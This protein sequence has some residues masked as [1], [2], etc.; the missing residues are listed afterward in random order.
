MLF[1]SPL[2]ERMVKVTHP[3]LLPPLWDP[4][5]FFLQHKLKVETK[6]VIGGQF[7]AKTQEQNASKNSLK[8]LDHTP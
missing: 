4:N 6:K 7:V 8:C 1:V 2:D 3:P 5:S